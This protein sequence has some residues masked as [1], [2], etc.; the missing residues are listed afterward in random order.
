MEVFFALLGV[1]LL[2]ILILLSQNNN[3][4]KK[5]SKGKKKTKTKQNNVSSSFSKIN[6]NFETL[7]DVQR[8]LRENGLESSNLIIAVDFTGSNEWQGEKTFD[9]RCLHE[10]SSSRLNPYQQSIQL[11]GEVLSAFDDGMFR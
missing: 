7:V 10:I 2:L 3:D 4:S 1:L 9:G 5:E 11:I 6:D 8:A